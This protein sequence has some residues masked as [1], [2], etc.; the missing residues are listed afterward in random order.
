MTCPLIIDCD[1]GKDDA[2]ALLLAFAAPESFRI[3][4]ITTVAGNVPLELTQHNARKICELA[5]QTHLPVYAGCPRPLLQPLHTAEAVHGHTGLDGPNLPDPQMPLQSTHA[6][7]FLVD[8]LRQASE[9]ITLAVTG[10]MTNVAMA[11]VKDPRILSHIDEIV[12]MGGS[13]VEGNIT[14]AAEFNIYVDPHAAHVVLTSGV[15]LTMIGL[16]VTHN[17]ITTAQR[18]DRI[19]SLNTPV[20]EATAILLETYGRQEQA[21]Y[22]E[23]GAPLHDPCVIAYLLKPDLFKTQPLHVEVELNSSLTLGKTVVDRWQ[24]RGRQPN[25]TVVTAVDAEGFYTLLLHYLAR[26]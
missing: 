9:P 11:I 6:V 23:P 12:F 16:H 14:P 26:L 8:T 20:A 21:R 2:V 5:G 15:K 24:V 7:D 13:A 19:R 18:L 10:P 22:H 1:P 17:V 4:G 25:V 3:L